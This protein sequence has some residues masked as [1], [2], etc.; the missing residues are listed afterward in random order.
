M[1]CELVTKAEEIM[2]NR[3]N[4]IIKDGKAGKLK[5]FDRT[6]ECCCGYYP[7]SHKLPLVNGILMDAQ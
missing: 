1:T 5:L 2:V 4:G 6:V 3:S 7:T